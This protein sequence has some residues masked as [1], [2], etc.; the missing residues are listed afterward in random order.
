MEIIYLKWGRCAIW[1][2]R[3]ADAQSLHTN[4]DNQAVLITS[5]SFAVD[6]HSCLNNALIRCGVGK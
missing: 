6:E 3:S 4:G 2:S 1:S 5:N